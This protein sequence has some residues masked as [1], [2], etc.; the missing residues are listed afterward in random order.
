VNLKGVN[1]VNRG[2]SWNNEAANCQSSNRNRNNPANRNHNNGFRLALNSNGPIV[3]WLEADAL[4]FRM[5]Q[6]IFLS[7][8]VSAWPAKPQPETAWC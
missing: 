7:G 4:G 1:R 8:P 5:E 3:G 6:F 2:G